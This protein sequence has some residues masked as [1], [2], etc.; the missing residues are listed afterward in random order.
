MQLESGFV[1]Y[2]YIYLDISISTFA[3]GVVVSNLS[4]ILDSDECLKFFVFQAFKFM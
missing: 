2:K 3:N 4:F 1:R